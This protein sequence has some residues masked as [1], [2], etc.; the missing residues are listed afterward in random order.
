MSKPLGSM[1]TIVTIMEEESTAEAQ[2]PSGHLTVS[3]QAG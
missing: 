1:S 3:R 2:V